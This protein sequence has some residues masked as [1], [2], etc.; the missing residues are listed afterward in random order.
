MADTQKDAI[1]Q[2]YDAL[3]ASGELE[4]DAHQREVARYFDELFHDIQHRPKTPF[5]LLGWLN[6]EKH[7]RYVRSLYLWGDVGRGKS[8]LMD[9]F[10][11]QLPPTIA[12]RRIHFHSF[13]TEIH[14]ALHRFRAQHSDKD[15]PLPHIAKSFSENCQLLC[16]DEFQVHDIAD[17]M[18]LSR[19]FESL[20]AENVVCVTTSNRPPDG[21]YQH[22]LQR[23]SF[24]PFIALVKER[25]DI[26]SL[27]HPT[28]YRLQKL[29]GSDVYFQPEDNIAPM[30]ELFDALRHHEPSAVQLH[31]KGRDIPLNK[32][33]DGMVWAHF[34]ELCET[35]LGAE[36]YNHLAQEYHTVFLTNIPRMTKENRNEARRFVHLIDA[37]Y[38]HRTRLICS[39]DAPAHELYPSGDGSFE[40]QRTVSRLVE[41]QSIAYLG[42]SHD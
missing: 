35:A 28:D 24:L 9:L 39:A 38:E 32:T 22:G 36:D 41:M 27:D 7:E 31:V 16:L 15:D 4:T 13:M 17:A 33:A 30:Q 19:L 37:L 11:D 42:A 18:I 1:T 6:S 12:A 2:A 29:Q 40:F 21:L 26:I 5:S 23:D 3:V 10:F 25:F 8:M 34:S 14:E 20:L